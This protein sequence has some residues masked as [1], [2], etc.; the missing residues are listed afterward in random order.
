MS[1]AGQPKTVESE[2]KKLA[3]PNAATMVLVDHMNARSLE[4]RFEQAKSDSEGAVIEKLAHTMSLCTRLHNEAAMLAL[5]PLVK[6]L[7]KGG[8]LSKSMGEKVQKIEEMLEQIEGTKK[9]LDNAEFVKLM[10]AKKKA[11]EEQFEEEE[12]V[13]AMIVSELPQENLE[14][15]ATNME[16]AKMKA[17]LAPHKEVYA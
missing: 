6:Q 9:H 14:T 15:G 16:E 11:C 10:E 12:Q 2:A 13:L 7:K 3:S 17:S 8:T 4:Q 5:L 1:T